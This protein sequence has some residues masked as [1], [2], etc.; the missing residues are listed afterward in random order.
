MSPVKATGGRWERLD[1]LRKILYIICYQCLFFFAHMRKRV[2]T[3]LHCLMIFSISI[4]LKKSVQQ[5]ACFFK[6]FVTSTKLFVPFII[7]STLY[8]SDPAELEASHSYFPSSSL[9]AFSRLKYV[10]SVLF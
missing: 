10:S 6:F 1:T 2:N 9:L 4:K 5:T 3:S 8:L 7:T